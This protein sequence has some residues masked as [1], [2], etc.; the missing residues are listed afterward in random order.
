MITYSIDMLIK[1]VDKEYIT[2]AKNGMLNKPGFHSTASYAYK[3][4]IPKDKIEK[5]HP[6]LGYIEAMFYINGCNRDSV[7]LELDIVEDAGYENSLFKID[8]LLEALTE[9]RKDVIN[10]KAVVDARKARLEK[11]KAEEKTND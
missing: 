2:F 9:L 8:T 5:T 7:S 3:I 6:F 1:D 11:L 10:A 4:D